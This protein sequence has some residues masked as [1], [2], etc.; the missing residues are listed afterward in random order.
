MLLGADS[1]EKLKNAHVAVFGIG[2]VGGFTVEALARAGVGKLTLIDGDT[3]CV[4]NINR[5]IIAN[6]NTIGQPKATL[7]QSRIKE[8][9]PMAEVVALDLFYLEESQV[10]LSQ[11]DYIVDAVDTVTAKLLLAQKATELGV[12]IISSM[13][14]AN[15]LDPTKFVV[16]DIYKTSMCPLAKVMRKELRARGVKKLKV[17]YSTEQPLTPIEDE[18]LPKGNRRQLPGSVSFVPPV[19]GLV[20]A[21]EVVK[22]L[23]R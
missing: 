11:F 23:A 22:D 3:V 15:K 20:V 16:T 6:H 14:A 18:T 9:N 2:G 5:Q 19:A 17:V 8:I 10:D 7:M 12:P 4:T 1:I 21:G 13:G